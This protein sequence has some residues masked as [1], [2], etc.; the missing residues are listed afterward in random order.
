MCIRDRAVGD[1]LLEREQ[2]RSGIVRPPPFALDQP[3]AGGDLAR[4]GDAA[5]ALQHPGGALFRLEILG[6]D[7]VGG[8]D[9]AAQ[10]RHFLELR[11]RRL[12][13]HEGVEAA[14]LAGRSAANC[15]CK[16]PSI[17][18]TVTNSAIPKPS[19]STMVGVSAPGRWILAMAM[20]STVERARGAWR[21]AV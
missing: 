17:S 6:R 20:R 12:R 4:I 3:R 9:A 10:H 8:D 19:E 14:G 13:A 15:R 1:L 18:I 7:T 16:L 2:R 21:A 11:R 5:V